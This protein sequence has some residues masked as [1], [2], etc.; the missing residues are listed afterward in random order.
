M[1]EAY[2]ME[3]A[4][5]GPSLAPVLSSRATLRGIVVQDHLQHLPEVEKVVGGWIRAGLFRYKEDITEGLAS[6]PD[7]FGRLM[8]GESFGK[9]LVR[10]APEHL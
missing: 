2:N 8:R 3:V 4:A 5:P 1:C 10:V 6:A 7:A 9:V